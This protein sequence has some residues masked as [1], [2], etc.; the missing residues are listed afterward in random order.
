[1]GAVLNMRGNVWEWC[2]DRHN[3]FPDDL[4]RVNEHVHEWR[5]P[6]DVGMVHP[7]LQRMSL[8]ADII[9]AKRKY[10]ERSQYE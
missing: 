10:V 7:P 8:L 1:M 5:D 2:H 9:T 3:L 6:V 4:K